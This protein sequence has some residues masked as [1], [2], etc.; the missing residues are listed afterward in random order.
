MSRLIT[1]RFT[2]AEIVNLLHAAS[3]VMDHDDAVRSCFGGEGTS[4][5]KA[6]RRAY[7]RMRAAASLESLHPTTTK[8]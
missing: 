2:R 1:I 7:E 6:A 4:S 8:E 3:N 5:G